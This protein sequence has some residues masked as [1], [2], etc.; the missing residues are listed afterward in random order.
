MFEAAWI[1]IVTITAGVAFGV[2][3]SRRVEGPSAYWVAAVGTI[4]SAALCDFL[5]RQPGGSG[6]LVVPEY[7]LSMAY[8]AILLAGA[9]H[10]SGSRVPCWREVR[11]DN[12]YA[13][14]PARPLLQNVDA[15]RLMGMSDHAWHDYP[16]SLRGTL[17]THYIRIES[18]S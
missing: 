18:T 8:P 6:W 12:P 15:D 9:L 14:S 11:K 10:I 16:S 4:F 5:I 7:A 1:A 3:R 2:E 17:R 13:S